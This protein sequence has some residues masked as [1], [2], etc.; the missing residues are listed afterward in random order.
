MTA[1]TDIDVTAQTGANQGDITFT[2]TINDDASGTAATLTLDADGGAISI[3]G[4]IGA[5]NAIGT[6]DINQDAT[7]HH[8]TITLKG[9]GNSAAGAGATN[10]G[11]ASTDQLDLAGTFFTGGDTTYESKTGEFIDITDTSTFKTGT[12]ADH[13]IVF[14]TGEIDIADNKN[15]TINSGNGDITLVNIHGDGTNS[16]STTTLDIDGATVTVK[17]IGNS[18]VK[19]EIGAVTIDLSLIHI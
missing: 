19:D 12:S 9:I 1:N 7:D 13:D 15:L 16:T 8:G 14:Q 4:A 3:G 18:G 17:E 10:I 11:N 2:S 6:L 5:N